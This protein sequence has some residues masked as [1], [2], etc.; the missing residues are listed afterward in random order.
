[1]NDLFGPYFASVETCAWLHPA[2]RPAHR[3]QPPFM[4]VYPEIVHH[5]DRPGT[6]TSGGVAQI[7]AICR[8]ND[9][10][11]ATSIEEDCAAIGVELINPSSSG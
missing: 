9:A 6:P 3:H 5:R 4:A 1:M 8:V 10:D 2:Y 7:A 11:L